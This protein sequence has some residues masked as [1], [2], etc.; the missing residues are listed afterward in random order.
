MITLTKARVPE[1]NGTIEIRAEWEHS[2]TPQCS[3]PCT[4][5]QVGRPG[6][7]IRMKVQPKG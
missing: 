1:L 5:N 4:V 3:V 6:T 2:C 7:D